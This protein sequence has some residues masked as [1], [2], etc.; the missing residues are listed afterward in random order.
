MSE[1]LLAQRMKE[2]PDVGSGSV[3]KFCTSNFE[4]LES[5]EAIPVVPGRLRERYR[6][7]MQEHTATL[8]RLMREERIDYALFN[9]AQPLDHA[10]FAYLADRQRLSRIR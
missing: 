6:T 5:G 7:L 10:L 2:S 1:Y 8:A 3:W 4:D 9:T